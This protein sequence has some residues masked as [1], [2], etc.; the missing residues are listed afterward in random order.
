M[1]PQPTIRDLRPG[2][3]EALGRLLVQ[4]Y[5]Q[6]EGFPTPAE[7]PRY[8]E[9]LANIGSFAAKPDTRVL[10]AVSDD[11]KLL[12]GVVYF[13][14]M[15]QYG[16]GGAATAV[17]NAS[18]IRLL[19]VD[20]ALRKCGAGKALTQACIALARERGHAQVILHTTQAMKIAWG[21]YEKL[22]FERSP[23]LDFAQQELQVFGFRLKFAPMAPALQ[24]I[25]HVHVYVADRKA[26]QAWYADVLGF[27]P[28]AALASWAA[29]P[30]PLTIGDAAGSVHIALFERPP[31]PCRSVVA[32]ATGAAGF[33]AWRAHL[34]GKLGKPVD[35]VD[36]E[37]SWSM[38]FSDPDGNPY[39]ITTYEYEAVRDGL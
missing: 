39:E 37:L 13:A 32:F 15:A 19:G 6:L 1:S 24:R 3:S 38:Y 7:Q 17:T 9:M 4:A 28:V 14:D 5:S 36:H 8:Y 22:G 29:G 35:A 25:D 11:E 10:V 26:A 16:S 33:L 31:Q 20:P 23:D 21:L 2:E 18:G 27:T 12:G 34:A 30:G